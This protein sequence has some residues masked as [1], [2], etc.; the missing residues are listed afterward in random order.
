M[1]NEFKFLGRRSFLKKSAILTGSALPFIGSGVTFAQTA[2]NIQ[3]Q[4]LSDKVLFVK[5]PDSNVLVVDSS[6]GLI[7]VDGGHA[8]WFENLQS[9]IAEN[10]PGRPY[11]ALF[12]THWHSEQTGANQPLG[13]QGV[14]I[15]AHENTMLWESTEVWQRWSDI[16][17]PA[18]PTVALP[19]KTV[20]EDGAIQIGDRNVQYGYM[21]EAHTDGDIWVYFEDEDV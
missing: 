4:R 6:E 18:L 10:F 12:N 17:F 21:R 20:F 5:G 15:I 1:R 8:S 16:T 3:T 14:E 19:T 7:L 13:E 11:R 2:N 9:A